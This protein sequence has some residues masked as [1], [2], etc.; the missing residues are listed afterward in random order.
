MAKYITELNFSFVLTPQC[1]AHTQLTQMQGMGNGVIKH[2]S[3]FLG[4]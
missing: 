1:E 2:N 3:M 4:I